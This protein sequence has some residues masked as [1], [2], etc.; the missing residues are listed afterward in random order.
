MIEAYKRL[1]TRAFDFQGRSTRGDYWWA[2]LASTIIVLTLIALMES[3]EE[4]ESLYTIYVCA[5]LIPNF[6][7]SIRRVRDAGKGWQ[8]IFINLIPLVGGIWFLVILCQ[9][10]M[11]IA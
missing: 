7:L 5:G 9:P 11:P 4:F 8:W 10:S 3:A 2:A 6:S 1:W